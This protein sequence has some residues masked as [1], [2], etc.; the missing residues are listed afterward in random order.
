MIFVKRNQDGKITD[1][2]LQSGP[3]YEYICISSPELLN[4]IQSSPDHEELTRMILDQLDL[5]MVRVIEDL[6]DIMIDRNLM[7]FTDL[8][9]AVQN[10]L[11]FKRKIRNMNS[12]ESSFQEE[13][14]LNF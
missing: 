10:K 11:L 2:K 14:I 8:P 4:Y 1:I 5:D 3:N 12:D 13:E 7:R 9:E 6:I